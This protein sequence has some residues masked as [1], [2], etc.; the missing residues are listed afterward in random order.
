MKKY[1]VNIVIFGMAIFGL[2]AN[3]SAVNL[4]LDVTFTDSNYQVTSTDTF[5]DLLAA[6]NAANVIS[7]T[8]VSALDNI[9]TSVYAGNIS[10]DYS[11][12]MSATLNIKDAG[13]Y[14]FE[15]G[16]DW[17]RG[18][19]VALFESVTN[20]LLS[21][22]INSTDIWWHNNWNH[23]D[24]IGTSYNFSA[25]TEYTLMWLGFEGCCAGSSTI[26]FSYEG[27]PFQIANVTNLTPHVVPIPPAVALF[28]P[29]L[30]ALVSRRRAIQ[31]Q[32][33]TVS[34]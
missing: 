1:L 4:S 28:V 10:G 26:R 3:A 13:D 2:V 25:N 9:D 6:H 24:V 5:A 15:V 32:T 8:N 7:T 23:P 30:V 31:Q 27:S 34:V 21:E 16:T 19:G 33:G 18:G 20:T 29:A 17:G 12:L 22:T 11:V 14:V